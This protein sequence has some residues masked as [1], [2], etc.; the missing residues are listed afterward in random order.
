MRAP[1]ILNLQR[2]V[3]IYL[4]KNSRPLNAKPRAVLPHLSVL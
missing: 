2:K 1:C 4:T 3:P